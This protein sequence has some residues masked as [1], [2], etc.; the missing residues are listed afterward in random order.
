MGAIATS[1]EVG[2]YLLMKM[3]FK[4]SGE[5][6]PD[7]P[8]RSPLKF[9][10]NASCLGRLWNPALV[11]L[12]T[13]CVGVRSRLSSW[14]HP[15]LQKEGTDVPQKVAASSSS[16]PSSPMRSVCVHVVGLR[17]R[18]VAIRPELAA[19]TAFRQ[20][21]GDVTAGRVSQPSVFPLPI[22]TTYTPFVLYMLCAVVFDC[23]A[24]A[25][26]VPALTLTCSKVNTVAAPTWLHVLPPLVMRHSRT[27]FR[28]FRF[29]CCCV[30]AF[31]GSSTPWTPRV[32][33]PWCERVLHNQTSVRYSPLFSACLLL[34]FRI[35]LLFFFNTHQ[36]F[37]GFFLSASTDTRK[38]N[39][40][41]DAIDRAPAI[42]KFGPPNPTI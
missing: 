21:A 9:S 28:Q 1:L 15:P 19:D 20:L 31:A 41:L 3:K 30:R 34:R 35:L 33:V 39:C 36:V 2:R 26:W 32:L 17:G 16:S 14:M 13:E 12:E 4:A 42:G 24:C 7:S 22:H 5:A 38:R 6:C 10:W 29:R 18:G 11:I 37:I 27:V 40:K 25:R 8:L 23:C